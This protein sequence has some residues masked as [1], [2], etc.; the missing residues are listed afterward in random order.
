MRLEIT[1]MIQTEVDNNGSPYSSFDFMQ[2]TQ[3]F[4]SSTRF[5]GLKA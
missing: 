1:L 2:H 4:K 3:A 5:Q